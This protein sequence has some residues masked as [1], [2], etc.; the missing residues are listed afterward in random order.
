MKEK[1]LADDGRKKRASRFLFWGRASQAKA[2]QLAEAGVYLLAPARLGPGEIS[3]ER[4]HRHRHTAPSFPTGHL[5]PLKCNCQA[6]QV[7]APGHL[8]ARAKVNLAL[9]PIGN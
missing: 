9:P 4:E 5:A 8:S 7:Q 3:W 1:R 6:S 2:L